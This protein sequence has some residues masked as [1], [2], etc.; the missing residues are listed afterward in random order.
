[1]EDL[2]RIKRSFLDYVRQGVMLN[3]VRRYRLYQRQYKDFAEYCK[4]ALGRSHFYCK[5]I[6]QAAEICLQLIKSKLK[7]LPTSVAQAM[8]L[9]KFAK[10]DEYG[11]S[12]LQDKWQSVIDGFPPESITASKIQETLDESPEDR[13]KQVR[14]GGRAY[15]LLQQKAA[16]A[17]MAVSKYLEMLIGGEPSDDDDDNAAADEQELTAEKAEICDRAELYIKT[18]LLRGFDISRSSISACF[19]LEKPSNPCEAYFDADIEVFHSNLENLNRLRLKIESF[20][21]DR[22]VAICEPTGMNYAKLWINKLGDWGVEIRMISNSKLPNYRAELLGKDGKSGAK[23]DDIDAFAIACW[24]FDKPET[25]YLKVRAPVVVQIKGICLRIEHLNRLQ[26]PIIN[27]MRQELSWQCPEVA[28]VR[29][30]KLQDDLAPLLWGWIA[31][32]RVSKKYDLA[33][34]FVER[35]CG[36]GVFVG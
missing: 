19:M 14:I 15:Q 21:A 27:R 29:S 24:Y 13:T 36:S 4:F 6:I 8:P 10:V 3:T 30:S 7:I 31:G 5:K 33:V 16:E 18:K 28:L 12:Q 23:T 22:V 25:A 26:N 2:K 34:R 9:L 35:R 17:G 1:M 20:K 11:H 32:R